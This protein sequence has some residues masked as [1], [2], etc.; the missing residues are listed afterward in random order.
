MRTHKVIATPLG[1]FTL[2]AEDSLLIAV[3]PSAPDPAAPVAARFGLA[4]ETGFEAAERQLEEFFQGR[5]CCFDLPVSQE[6]TPFQRQV[7]SAVK[8]IPY[9]QTRTYKQL[10]L[11]LGAASKA[12]GV[13]AAL[14]RNMLNIVVPT[15]RVLGSRGKL[16]GYSGGVDAK[17][18]LLDLEAGPDNEALR[19]Q[20]SGAGVPA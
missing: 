5:R 4:A 18:M 10:A 7:W 2:V 3:E 15:H 17:R 9:G 14:A 20:C 12:R 1:I 13:G 6:G 19:Q 11:E 16:T 8:L